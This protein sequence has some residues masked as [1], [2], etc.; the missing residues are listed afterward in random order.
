MTWIAQ[1]NT[2]EKRAKYFYIIEVKSLNPKTHSGHHYC[3][4]KW[5][6]N[7]LTKASPSYMGCSSDKNRLFVTTRWCSLLD[8][9]EKSRGSWRGHLRD[10]ANSWVWTARLICCPHYGVWNAGEL[11]L[12]NRLHLLVYVWNRKTD[13]RQTLIH[14]NSDYYYNYYCCCY[15]LWKF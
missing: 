8:Q 12:N 10:T 7:K 11:F 6:Q 13:H 15:Y 4:S 1:R 5:Q 3:S 2:T 14:Y 9:R